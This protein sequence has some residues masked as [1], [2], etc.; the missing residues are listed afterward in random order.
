MGQYHE[1]LELIDFIRENQE[2]FYRIAYSYVKEQ[3]TALDLVQDAIVLALQNRH[4]L[5]KASCTKSWFYRILVN[6][7]LG[8]LR[9]EKKRALFFQK[10]RNE[11]YH[12]QQEIGIGDTC[13]D[14]Y[15][16]LDKLTPEMKTVVLLRFFEDM[17]LE[18][19]AAVL[20]VSPNTVKSRLYRA[21][22]LLKIKLEVE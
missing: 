21:L 12:K 22:K 20:K 2:A 9:K 5:R 4:T 15:A 14:L 16:A 3:E 18:E 11:A 7:C 10:T 8:Y 6:E 13:T 19:I 1:D 17:K